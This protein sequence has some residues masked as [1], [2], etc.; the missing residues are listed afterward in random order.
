MSIS[1]MSLELA[2]NYFHAGRTYQESQQIYSA[3]VSYEKSLQLDPHQAEVWHELGLGYCECDRYQEGIICY[4]EALFIQMD[5]RFFTSLVTVLL[6]IGRI[7][8]AE[9]ASASIISNQLLLD[10]YPLSLDQ[11]LNFTKD[12]DLIN[13][14]HQQVFSADTLSLTPPINLDNFHPTFLRKEVKFP[15]ATVT[16]LW[17]G[18]AIATDWASVVMTSED[19]FLPE[20]STGRSNWLFLLKDKPELKIVPG[21]VL[22]LAR[23]GGLK[24][25]HWLGE[26]FSACYL[27]TLAG[28][29]L[30]TID[31][32]LVNSPFP[33]YQQ[34]MLAVLG[35]NQDKILM[36]SSYAYI[37]A[38]ELI[39]P[40]YGN[41]DGWFPKLAV[42]FLKNIFLPDRSRDLSYLPKRVYLSRS[43]VSYRQVINEQ[44][45]RDFLESLGF[46]TIIPESLSM[47]EQVDLF[48]Q[49]EIIVSPHGAGLTNAMFCAK[50]TK[51]I[52]LFTP[53]YVYG[54]FWAIASQVGLDYYYLVSQARGS[55]RP[56][57]Q[58]LIHPCYR[59]IYVDI[60]QLQQLLAQII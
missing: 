21:R 27:V 57:P 37:Q 55:D 35:I 46:V 28:I 48:S 6:K 14:K 13:S 24:Y 50:G 12:H 47:A 39:I 9:E 56:Q 34:E 30:T 23:W 51:V 18:K 25:F 60:P 2:A 10:F 42:D 44:E 53:D 38:E 29:D 3:I 8:E 40:Y 33:A 1:P 54:C 5:N 41:V 43:Q 11:H 49:V 7:S 19:K 26:V 31:Y 59:D 32:F 22:A 52:E 58:D 15:A 36:T 45:I 4:L 16:S 17:H 20:I